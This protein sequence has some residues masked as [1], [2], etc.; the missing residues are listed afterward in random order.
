MARFLTVLRGEPV[1][2]EL[3]LVSMDPPKFA[4]LFH[5]GA[6]VGGALTRKELTFLCREAEKFEH[7][8]VSTFRP[9]H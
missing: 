5:R 1:D 6:P 4:V 8:V 9:K 3:T 7:I 2:V